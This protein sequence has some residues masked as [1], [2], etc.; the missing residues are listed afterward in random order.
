[1]DYN[2]HLFASSLYSDNNVSY[3]FVNRGRRCFSDR[4]N[5]CS[6]YREI[7]LVVFKVEGVGEKWPV[8]GRLDTKKFKK[9]SSCASKIAA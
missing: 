5:H 2:P 1:M 8:L 7:T 4:G 3:I 9:S 6:S